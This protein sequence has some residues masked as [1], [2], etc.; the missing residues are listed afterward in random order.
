M[1]E[2][3]TRFAPSPTGFMHIGNLRTALFEYLVAKAQGGKFVLRIED[4]DRGR[5]VEGATD[6]IYQTLQE[7]GMEH[8]EGP[9]IGGPYAPYVQSERKDL[10]RP[11]AEELVKKGAA[12]Y[13][14]CSHHQEEAEEGE[15]S[16][17][18]QGYNRACR[19]LPEEVVQQYLKEGRP[20][21]IRQKMP[22][23][24]QTT[25]HDEVY[26]SITVDNKEL[27]DQILLKSDGFPTYNFANVVDDHDM[28]ITHVVRGSEYLSST[29]KY[30]LLYEAFGYE[31]PTYIH[32][33]LI[34]GK[35]GKKLSKR[36]GATSFAGLVSEGYLPEAIINYIALLG[37][38]PG[39]KSTE[40][41]FTLEDLKQKFH[42]KGISKSPAVFDYDKLAW[43]NSVYIQKMSLEAFAELCAPYFAQV[44]PDLK[45]PLLL[46]K[47]LQARV[48]KLTEIPDM[49]RFLALHQELDNELYVHKKMKTDKLS[50][51][52]ILRELRPELADWTDWSEE[53]LHQ[54]L[55]EAA[56]RRSLKNGQLMWPLRIA[57]SAQAVTPGGAVE[58]LSLLGQE[59][60]LR[61]LDRALAR[62]AKEVE[63]ETEVE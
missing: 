18:F 11:A 53:G 32:L 29:P 52:A 41:L 38:S 61:R 1:K 51:L 37:W 55:L 40:E 22:L 63:S 58:I 43:F 10:Y 42:V 13:C 54:F 28:A 27:E 2:V 56:S 39:E 4:T 30:N 47:I 6:L 8:D 34:N 35:D 21:V 20:Y 49:I 62:L 25:F 15:E 16:K 19:D 57:V 44:L 5:L 26:G 46:A 3:R 45:Q 36:H 60:S 59:E 31:I 12:Y 17:G 9:D 33:P 24:G 50:S 23:T 7:V 14:F 48:K